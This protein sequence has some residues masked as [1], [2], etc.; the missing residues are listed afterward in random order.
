MTETILNN[1]LNFILIFVIS[2][3]LI[4]NILL[5]IRIRK[6]RARTTQFFKGKKAE[7]LEEVISEIFKKQ[8]TTEENIHKA[9]NKIKNLDK[10]A[11]HSIQKVGVIRFNPFSDIG[12]NQSFVVA[13]LDQKDDGVVISSLH[14]KEGTRIYAKPIKSGEST[15]PLSKEEE[16]AI[17]KALGK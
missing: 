17:R 10:V 6:E 2:C 13:F 12:S 14:A 1:N 16:E 11:L 15:Y 3:L 9:L 5:E 7:N 4:W 8:K